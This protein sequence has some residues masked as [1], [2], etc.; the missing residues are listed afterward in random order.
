MFIERGEIPA[1][2]KGGGKMSV[3]CKLFQFD[4]KPNSTKTPNQAEVEFIDVTGNTVG[5]FSVMRPVIEFDF[6]FPLVAPK[7][8][9]ASIPLFAPAGKGKKFFFI[10]DWTFRGGLWVASMIVDIVGTYWD[11]IN[12]KNFYILRSESEK[13]GALIDTA[14]PAKSGTSSVSNTLPAPFYDNFR[15]GFYVL[16]V[17]NGAGTGGVEYIVMTYSQLQELVGYMFSNVDYLDISASE[18]S[19]GLQKM[20]FN[21]FQY[22]VSAMWFPMGLP[23][24]ITSSG[25]LSVGWWSLAQNHYKITNYSMDRNFN[26]AVPKH[27]Q[28]NIKGKWVNTSPY[29]TY[30]LEFFPWGQ[31][32]LDSAKLVNAETLNLSYIVDLITGAGVL[33]V[34]NNNSGEDGAVAEAVAQVGVPI[35]M[36]Q[37]AYNFNNASLP[38]MIAAAGVGVMNYLGV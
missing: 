32:P 28:T 7:W 11:E 31:I 36:A 30:S 9:Y 23:S 34:T 22:F 1:Q 2:F 14:Y 18:V 20:L 38:N 25:N 29:S 21:P 3:P 19:E 24:G 35:T 5:D 8:N 10:T 13:D 17:V 33:R 16:G 15:N 12:D 37:I 26:I 27:P 6:G 4:K